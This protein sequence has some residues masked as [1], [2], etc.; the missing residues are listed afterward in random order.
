MFLVSFFCGNQDVL[1][2]NWI[3]L[4][5]FEFATFLGGFNNRHFNLLFKTM[6]DITFTLKRD[7]MHFFD[8]GNE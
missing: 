3:F 4:K 6:H 5:Y 1:I 2:I 7:F 8:D